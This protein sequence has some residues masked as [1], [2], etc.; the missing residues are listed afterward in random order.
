MQK[1]K[2]SNK[3]YISILICRRA[4]KKY[5]PKHNFE[6]ISLKFFIF[7]KVKFEKQKWKTL[8][9][10]NY[11]TMIDKSLKCKLKKKFCFF[12]TQSSIFLHLY[13][14]KAFFIVVSFL[15]KIRESKRYS[16]DNYVRRKNKRD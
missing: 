11:K 4:V 14:A 12:S 10:I 13:Y 7:A 16:F 9:C 15:F 1:N 8:K 2:K 5:N 6:T 3:S